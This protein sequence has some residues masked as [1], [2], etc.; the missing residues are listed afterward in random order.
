MSL[1]Y[2]VEAYA[3][4]FRRYKTIFAH[5]WQHRHQLSGKLL[6]EHE[7]E[8]LPAALSL[9]AKPVSPTAR[10]LARILMALVVVLIAW[11][12]LGKI[13]IIVNATGKIIPSGYTKTIASVDVASVR[14]LYVEEGQQVKAGDVLIELD[15]SASDA[16]RD[17]ATGDRTTALL[18]VARA[19]ALIA[20]IDGGH[21]PQFP[22]VDHVP[23]NEW[24]AERLHL[25]GQYRDYVAKLTRIDGDIARYRE[26]LPLAT[27]RA[28]DYKA[29]LNDHDVSN[30]AWLEKE[31]A[32]VDLAGQLADARNQRSALIEETRR[33][34]YDQLTEG[35]KAAASSQQDAL[36]SDAHSKLLKLT[37]P[38][39]GTVQQLDVHTVGGVVSSAKPLMQIVPQ[40]N[41]VE[42]EAFL[43][44]KDVGFVQ[45]GQ[46]AEVK[47]DAFEYTKYGTVTGKVT[48]VSRDA[49]QDEKKGLIYS[50]KI[51][52]DKSTIGVEG[53][54]ML[55][56]AGM[57]V[58]V[59]I[60]TGDRRII[61]YVL[62]C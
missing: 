28:S 6:T 54:E 29:L 61:E 39:S 25:E 45:E 50:T 24:Q 4:L 19:K 42:V 40:D 62:S 49:I 21:S 13:D 30:H 12:I 22:S 9:Q 5:H 8:F 46:S 34:A 59:E 2:R 53:K 33:T 48:H 17:K 52:L 58:N 14:A 11:S 38:V 23:A 20:A 56:S 7:A 16:D 43:E 44:N 18:Q 47:I 26:A 35:S 1:K 55:L 51:A 15:T 32:R 36:R 27:Q 37:A 41:R 3:E 31:Q 57:S 60:K 10:L